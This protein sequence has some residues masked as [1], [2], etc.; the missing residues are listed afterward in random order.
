VGKA[1]TA[2]LADVNANRF[3]TFKPLTVRHFSSTSAPVETAHRRSEPHGANLLSTQPS[4]EPASLSPTSALVHDSTNTLIQSAQNPSSYSKRD[5]SHEPAKST[6]KLPSTAAALI[7]RSEFKGYTDLRNFT[8][9]DLVQTIKVDK[10]VIR[11]REKESFLERMMRM[12]CRLQ[13]LGDKQP[14]F[15]PA[16]ISAWINANPLVKNTTYSVCRTSMRS[17]LPAQ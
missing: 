4:A 17:F 15:V 5:A 7:M 14:G 11:S 16:D 13:A 2:G 1:T 10:D 6:P 9:A 12:I 3:S 8:L